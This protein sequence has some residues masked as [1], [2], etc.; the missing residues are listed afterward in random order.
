M[1]AFPDRLETERLYLRP[2]S[3][4]DSAWY[5]DVARRNHAHLARYES[6]NAA[7]K[8]HDE[9]DADGILRAFEEDWRKRTAF[10][11]GVF[12]K[13]SDTFVAQLYA[14]V[15]NPDVP[16]VTLGFFADYRHEGNGY[17]TEAARAAI[18]VLLAETGVA[19]IVLWCDETNERSRRVA[20]RCGMR[21]EAH[22][23]QNKRHRDG[24]ITGTFCYALLREDPPASAQRLHPGDGQG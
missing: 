24:S 20:E 18:R 11:L 12:R 23:R 6:G 17:V 13:D 19:R 21:R 5:C 7:F 2:F 22:L 15:S 16:E 4:R 9:V 3:T 14:G 10:F 1:G 8:I